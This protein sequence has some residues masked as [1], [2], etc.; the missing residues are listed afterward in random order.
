MTGL[1]DKIED[2]D[3]KTALLDAVKAKERDVRL[4]KLALE[5][6]EAGVPAPVPEQD[7]G[8]I[9]DF[10]DDNGDIYK[11]IS[12]QGLSQVTNVSSLQDGKWTREGYVV[13]QN[14]DGDWIYRDAVPFDRLGEF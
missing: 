3:L 14:S 9:K 11:I 6:M 7:M 1:I 4:T 8:Y 12:R 2:Q 10:N 13:Q 5:A